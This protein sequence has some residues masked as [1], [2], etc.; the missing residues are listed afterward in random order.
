MHSNGTLKFQEKEISN[1][2]YANKFKLYLQVFPREQILVVDGDQLIV[3]PLP[4]VQ[5]V[6]RFLNLKPEIMKDN[7]Y[8]SEEKGFYCMKWDG[9]EKCLADAKGRK[10]PKVKKQILKKLRAYFYPYN[11]MFYNLSGHDFGWETP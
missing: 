8:F 10:H 5:K 2:L 9:I 4:I 6:E 11:Q 3:D 7:L 1:S